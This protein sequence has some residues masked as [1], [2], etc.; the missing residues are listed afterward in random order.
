MRLAALP[1]G[2]KVNLS[3]ALIE[4]QSFFG[5]FKHFYSSSFQNTDSPEKLTEMH[6]LQT[7][8][9][10]MVHVLLRFTSVPSN[11]RA[12]KFCEE[13]ATCFGL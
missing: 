11:N 6:I 8:G 9:H 7:I 1:P 3:D 2:I 12:A 4:A 13:I 5:I 10:M